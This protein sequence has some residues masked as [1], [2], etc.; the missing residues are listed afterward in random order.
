MMHIW[1]Y[2]ISN[3]SNMAANDA[4]ALNKVTNI[5]YYIVSYGGGYQNVGG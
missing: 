5:K 2:G 4:W 3:K 1:Y